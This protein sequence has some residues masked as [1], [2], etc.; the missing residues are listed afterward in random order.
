LSRVR[1]IVV[2]RLRG[3]VSEKAGRRREQ[4]ICAPKS[5]LRKVVLYLFGE[6]RGL[7][8]QICNLPY[9]RFNRQ[10]LRKVRAYWHMR[11]RRRMQFCD[12]AQRGE[13]ATKGARR[14]RRFRAQ[15]S[16]GCGIGITLGDFEH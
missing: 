16:T 12:T 2:L 14:L 15:S 9:H 6:Q 11:T 4:T 7:V 1:F 3:H 10:S 5:N 13:A 8:A